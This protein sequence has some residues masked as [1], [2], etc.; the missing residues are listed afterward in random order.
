[1]KIYNYFK[2][3]IRR[4]LIRFK[5]DI[6]IQQ[7]FRLGMQ[8]DCRSVDKDA[9]YQANYVFDFEIFNVNSIIGQEG[10]FSIGAYITLDNLHIIGNRYFT[11]VELIANVVYDALLF[12]RLT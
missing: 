11:L 8:R 10:V 2:R 5:G 3:S 7:Q 9:N 12:Y 4:V 6:P 1:M